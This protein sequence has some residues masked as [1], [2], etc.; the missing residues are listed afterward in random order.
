M[1]E[2]RN[3]PKTTGADADE[4]GNHLP[5]VLLAIVIEYAREI[6]GKL[7]SSQNMP[8]TVFVM[9]SE[10]GEP[11]PMINTYTYSTSLPNL[12]FSESPRVLSSH[13]HMC[14]SFQHDGIHIFAPF[15]PFSPHL[16][17]SSLSFCPLNTPNDETQHKLCYTLKSREEARKALSVLSFPF[18][19]RSWNLGRCEFDVVRYMDRFYA[20]FHGWISVFQ[21]DGTFMKKWE[22]AMPHA[23]T[24]IAAD[25]DGVYCVV[26]RF[27]LS[28]THH[29]VHR[30]THQNVETMKGLCVDAG[31]LYVYRGLHIDVFTTSGARTDAG[32]KVDN[33]VRQL[34]LFNSRMYV[35]RVGN[36]EN[37]EDTVLDVFS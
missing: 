37:Y 25:E 21:V 1:F 4:V 35:V 22:T 24:R 33:R 18:P 27:L 34:L 30:W 8:N 9:L 3:S 13:P 29:G 36:R 7:E 10:R 2:Q 19:H 28:Y 5:C 20:L 32:W 16:S 31:H 17:P 23:Y 11:L 15:L 6:T 26:D 14:A 12:D